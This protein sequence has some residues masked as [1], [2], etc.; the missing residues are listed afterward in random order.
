MVTT[1]ES[2][3][4]CG[5]IITLMKF[6]I[7]YYDIICYTI[8]LCVFIVALVLFLLYWNISRG[9]CIKFGSD[10]QV[11]ELAWTVIPTFIVVFLCSLKV[12][13]IT[14]GLGRATEDIV[15]IIGRQWYWTYDSSKG[16]YDSYPTR[17]C[18]DVD[19]PLRLEYGVPYCLLITSSDVI[20]SFA[21][22]GLGLKMDAIPGRINQIIFCPDRVG[23]FSGFCRELCGVNHGYMPIVIEVVKLK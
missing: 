1:D 3:V 13:F 5:S 15:K 2:V 12:K 8:A 7:L 4:N 23:R 16:R 19:K 20:H 6:R 18:F 11:L 9:G 14:H 10:K 22:P 17:D 21:V